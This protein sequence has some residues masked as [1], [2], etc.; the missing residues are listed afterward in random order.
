MLKRFITLEKTNKMLTAVR[1]QFVNVYLDV[2]IVRMGDYYL[3]TDCFIVD[4]PCG[5]FL[6]FFNSLFN[7]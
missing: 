7:F 6:H 4:T 2:K 5:F 3:F 1:S